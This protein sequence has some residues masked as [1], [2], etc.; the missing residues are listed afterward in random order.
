MADAKEV[1]LGDLAEKANLWLS[2]DQVSVLAWSA[3]ILL[4]EINTF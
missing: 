2:L 4:G 1:M 3:R